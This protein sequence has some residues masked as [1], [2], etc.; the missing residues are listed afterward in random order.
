[1]IILLSPSKTINFKPVADWVVGTKP[2]FLEQSIELVTAVTHLGPKL[3]SIFGVSK[4]IAAENQKQFTTWSSTPTKTDSCPAAWA[5]RGETFAGLSIEKFDK[6]ATQFAQ[7]HLYVISVLY[8][9][10]RPCDLI[11]HYR[12]EMTTRLKGPW[13]DTL[14]DF[15]EDTL[16]KYLE[17]QNPD[18]ILNCASEVYFSAVGRHLSPT[19]PVITPK[20]LHKGKQ[21]MAFAKY[22]RGLMARYAI[23]KR[24][25]NPQDILEFNAEGY[26]YDS[27]HSTKNEPVFNA[28][29][30]FSIAGRWKKT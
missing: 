15:W 22:S 13:G 12:L 6:P 4:N 8:G 11:S 18:F 26:V 25:T 23:E 29:K 27:L 1:M 3:A 21:K 24:I 28:P 14:Y 5:Y 30:D 20:F 9:L 7:K 2:Q 10:L 19:I 16:A 17:K